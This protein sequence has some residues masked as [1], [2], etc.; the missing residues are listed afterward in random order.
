MKNNF[1]IWQSKRVFHVPLPLFLEIEKRILL[2][3]CITE[4]QIRQ[5]K[6]YLKILIRR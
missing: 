3:E 4:M 2:D 1:Y 5:Y 6:N